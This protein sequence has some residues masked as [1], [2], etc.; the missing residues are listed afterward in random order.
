MFLLYTIK[1]DISKHL[2]VS[3]TGKI[4]TQLK[5]DER[6]NINICSVIL[7]SS[8]IISVSGSEGEKVIYIV[9]ATF[10]SLTLFQRKTNKGNII[11]ILCNQKVI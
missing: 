8:G 6:I 2:I 3:W 11:W 4:R 7:E 9:L 5:R 1:L 10:L